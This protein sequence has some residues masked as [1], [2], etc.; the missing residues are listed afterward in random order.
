MTIDIG[1]IG[2]TKP[3]MS[4]V[5]ASLQCFVLS[6]ASTTTSQGAKSKNIQ[7]FVNKFAHD[8]NV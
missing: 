2:P 1:I 6:Q 5:P 8:R 3:V 7:S 4:R